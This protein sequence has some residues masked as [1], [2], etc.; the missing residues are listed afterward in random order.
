MLANF[1]HQLTKI[2]ASIVASEAYYN[3]AVIPLQKLKDLQI[4]VAKMMMHIK[5]PFSKYITNHKKGCS[6]MFSNLPNVHANGD[7]N[8]SCVK[9]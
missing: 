6:L 5:C 8:R 9:G 3:N 1:P 7:H 2:S 4:L